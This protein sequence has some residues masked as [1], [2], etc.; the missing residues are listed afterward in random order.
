M[1]PDRLTG[2]D[3]TRWTFAPGARGLLPPSGPDVDGWLANGVASVVKHG[4]HRTVYRA[5]LPRVSLYWKRCRLLGLRGWLRQALRPPKA[6][7]EF[8]R[9]HRLAELGVPT[10]EPLAWGT[11]GRVLPGESVLI[12]RDRSD[13]RPLRDFLELDLPQLPARQ[14][15]ATRRLL[16]LELGAFVA[17]LHEAGVAH[18]DPHPGN[19]LVEVG[20][21]RVP[22]F[23]LI[24]L[25]AVRFGPPL[26]WPAARDNLVLFHRYFQLRASRAD[27]LRFWR[28][29]RARR[30]GWPADAAS[31]RS[32]A[33]E[34]ER[35]TEASN[36]RFWRGRAS[37]CLGDNRYF[38]RLAVGAV[39]GHAL[40]DIDADALKRLFADPDL[41]FRDPSAQLLKDGRS[42]AVVAL[43]LDTADG[44]RRVVWKRF[45]AVGRW[46]GLKN[47]VRPSPALRSWT[48][49]HALLD[50]GL[51]TARP[52]A[53][54]HRRE[55]GLP[56]TAYLLC[57][58]VPDAREL[59]EALPALPLAERRDAIERLG[60]LLATLHDRGVAHRDLKA[61]NLLLDAR[62]AFHFVDLVGVEPEANPTPARRARDLARLAASFLGEPR[63]TRTD[64]LRLIRAYSG[65]GLRGSAGWKGVWA[66]ISAHVRAKVSRNH[67]RGRP[68]G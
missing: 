35:A 40:R 26:Y 14:R 38:R 56:T 49:G 32:Q 8:D 24:D 47:L 27:R 16:A 54:C 63:L 58:L 61:A 55:R 60:Q 64:L 7:L 22:R 59:R 30:S 43:T 53:V 15:A 48:S 50:R 42:S 57:E 23:Y 21:D 12:T 66:A 45:N 25:H 9:A 4:P 13:T 41:P 44:P 36:R 28:S 29:Y 62:G 5:A 39:S 52:L 19:L 20:A 46:E 67:L 1:A 33:R 2:R 31:A 65:W 3:G 17:R 37:R 18:P 10:I 34:L 51:P 68:L 11:R 6:K